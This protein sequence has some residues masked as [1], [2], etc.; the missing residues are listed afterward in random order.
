MPPTVASEH[1]K[2]PKPSIA[3]IFLDDNS[4]ARDFQ[5][6]GPVKAS[7]QVVNGS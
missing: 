7:A 2:S 5:R 1:T 3:G 6:L 4:F